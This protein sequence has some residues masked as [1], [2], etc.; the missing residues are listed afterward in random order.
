MLFCQTRSSVAALPHR[1]WIHLIAD[2]VAGSVC[3]S[4]SVSFSDDMARIEISLTGTALHKNASLFFI[5][6]SF[7]PPRFPCGYST[8]PESRMPM[9][10]PQK[11]F[12][13][14]WDKASPC[15]VAVS[16]MGWFSSQENCSFWS[17]RQ[18][19]LGRIEKIR[20]FGLS[21]LNALSYLKK[22]GWWKNQVL[23]IFCLSAD[24]VDFATILLS[25]PIV[26]DHAILNKEQAQR[27]PGLVPMRGYN[28]AFL[29][30]RW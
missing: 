16:R 29:S 23:A 11:P 1:L 25:D 30:K 8:L 20:L 14:S 21:A 10:V 19:A 28:F 22:I 24:C 5:A 12:M 6:S 2:T 13:H 27:Y 9:Q 17:D 26:P 15:F 18:T 3:I 7:R 4:G